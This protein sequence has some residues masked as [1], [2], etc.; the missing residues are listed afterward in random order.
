[1]I[2]SAYEAVGVQ[3][4]KISYKSTRMTFIFA[5]LGPNHRVKLG[6]GAAQLHKFR[7]RSHSS[8]RAPAYNFLKFTCNDVIAEWA[9]PVTFGEDG[10]LAFRG[11]ALAHERSNA[12]KTVTAAREEMAKTVYRGKNSATRIG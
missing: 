5:I 6:D 12:T 7:P 2:I 11:L 1:M 3:S 9:L 4:L 8:C 10:L